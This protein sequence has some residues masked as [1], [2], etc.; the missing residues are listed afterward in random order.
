[1]QFDTAKEVS[2]DPELEKFLKDDPVLKPKTIVEVEDE[3]ILPEEDETS[4]PCTLE[5]REHIF[6]L[7]H[8]RGLLP[9]EPARMASIIKGIKVMNK[10]EADIYAEGLKCSNT[11]NFSKELTKKILKVSN[12]FL[13]PNDPLTKQ[14]IEGDQFLIDELNIHF[15]NIFNKMGR[16]KPFVIY[17]LY[18][19]AGYMINKWSRINE[20]IT[21]QYSNRSENIDGTQP[22]RNNVTS[23]VPTN[24]GGPVSNG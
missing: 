6:S 21:L 19:G 15:T 22:Q 3:D 9:T 17:G 20:P 7:L 8:N 13:V 14:H 24:D 4:H 16:L 1:M 5:Q 12:E 23:A 2:V 10:E 18:L 11:L